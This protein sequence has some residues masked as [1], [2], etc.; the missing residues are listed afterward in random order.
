MITEGERRPV[1]TGLQKDKKKKKYLLWAIGKH[2]TLTLSKNSTPE[3]KKKG[4]EMIVLEQ[5]SPGSPAVSK[6][7]IK[8]NDIS[9]ISLFHSQTHT[10]VFI[11]IKCVS[12]RS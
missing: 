3:I 10:D 1:I 8:M 11:L 7:V 6:L 4:H 2:L 5:E 12:L 9:M